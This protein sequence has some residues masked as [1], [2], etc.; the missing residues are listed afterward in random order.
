MN[1][2]GLRALDIALATE[3]RAMYA[4]LLTQE[5]KDKISSLRSP[6]ELVAFLGRSEAWRPASLALPATGATDEQ[7]SEALNRCLFDDYERLYRFAN[8]ASRGYL[9]FWTYEV[10]LKVL[11]STLRRLSD[12]AITEFV[13]LPS[14]AARQMRS[15]NLERLKTAKSFDDVKAA[16]KDS[17][18]S[19]ILNAMEIDPKTGIPD[20]TTASMQLA[21]HF[22]SALGKH[23][24]SGYR[25]PSKREL[26]RTVT[27]RT[28]MLNI[29]YLLRLRRFGTPVQQAMDM[30]LPLEGALSRDMQRRILEADTD[31]DAVA[32]IR[33]SRLGKWLAGVEDVSPEQLG[34]AAETAYY[35]KVMHGTPN[36]C[37]VDAF[38]TLKENE[39]DMLRR[40]FVALQYGLSPARYML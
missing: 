4:H 11:L 32:L 37:V 39:A 40:A 28:D 10:E 12:T 18:Y 24:A 21:S 29:S 16:V 5:D 27:F 14:Q 35:R 33:S 3:A 34:R 2:S 1:N 38:L 6:D 9:I 25:G 15:V 7:F 19:P 26:K 13:P 20:L 22:Y 31:E 23:L 8:D 30:L 36:L 17:L